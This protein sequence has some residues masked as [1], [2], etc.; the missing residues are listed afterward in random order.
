PYMVVSLGGVGAA[1]DAL[2]ATRHLTPLGGHNVLWVLG[3]S[4]PT[5]LLLLGESGI[6]QKFFSAKDEN[7]ARRAVLGMVVG[8]VLLETAL[9]LLAITGRAAFPGLEGGTSIIGRAASE[10][11]IL[12]I[13]R[14]A[15]PAVGGA[16]LLAAGIAIVLS[17]GN[18]FML[19][20]STNA[21]R[22]IYQRFAN[23]DASE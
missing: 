14:H 19:V 1:A 5:F 15:L 7:A 12:H 13:A 22:D 8:V 9:A 20:A 2:S 10:T 3:V 21:T 11:V 16:V 6:Y 23:P 18:T 4:L 17:T